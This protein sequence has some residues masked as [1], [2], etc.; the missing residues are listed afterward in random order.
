MKKGTL[1]I[2]LAVFSILFTFLIIFPALFSQQF[3][4]FLFIKYGVISP[5]P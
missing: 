5:L 1:L 2:V 3:G 4:P